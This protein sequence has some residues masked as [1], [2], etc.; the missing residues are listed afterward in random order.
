MIAVALLALVGPT[1]GQIAR[2]WH[3][4]APGS[5]Q[6]SDSAHAASLRQGVQA[7][8]NAPFGHGLGLAG[9]AT[10]HAGQTN[11]I[12]DDYLQVGYE[13]GLIGLILFIGVVAAIL[14][15][16]VR[17][18]ASR[19]NLGIAAAVAGI[20]LTAVVLPAWTD[21]STALTVWTL[22]GTALGAHRV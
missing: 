6:T 10:F 11:I 21:S 14:W 20:S 4:S 18:P 7:V 19:L 3:H 15:A 8:W 1:S 5:A 16:L 13:T 12:E 17:P 2:Y 9:P 22:A